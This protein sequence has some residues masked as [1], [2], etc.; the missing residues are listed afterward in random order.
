MRRKF[1][2]FFLAPNKLLFLLMI[3]LFDILPQPRGG[4]NLLF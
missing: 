3:S 4:E 2:A 1:L